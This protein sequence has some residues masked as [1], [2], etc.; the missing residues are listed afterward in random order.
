MIM[1]FCP[2]CGIG[3]SHAEQTVGYCKN[4]HCDFQDL[5]IKERKEW[6]GYCR[7]GH[8]HSEHNPINSVNYSS[9][10]CTVGE[11]RCKHFIHQQKS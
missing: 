10:N 4:C 11:C 8:K 6:D 2:E 1:K 7:C 5:I 3:L 9:G